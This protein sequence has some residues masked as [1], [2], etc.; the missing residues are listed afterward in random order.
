M[1]VPQVKTS[2]VEQMTQYKIEKLERKA[3]NE[4]LLARVSAKS[5]K[6]IY[7]F[8]YRLLGCFEQDEDPRPVVME[9]GGG[10]TASLVMTHLLNRFIDL[11]PA[12]YRHALCTLELTCGSTKLTCRIEAHVT[13]VLRANLASVKESGFSGADHYNYFKDRLVGTTPKGRNKALTSEEVDVMLEPALLFLVDASGVPVLLS[14][15]VLIFSAGGDDLS[16]L[17]TNQYKLY[18]LGIHHAI[19]KRLLSIYRPYVD[20]PVD[21]SRIMYNDQI[22]TATVVAIWQQMFALTGGQNSEKLLQEIARGADPEATVTEKGAAAGKGEKGGKGG[23]GGEKNL[24]MGNENKASGDVIRAAAGLGS[25]DMLYE[26]LRNGAH[27]LHIAT[28]GGTRTV[29]NKIELT[30]AKNIRTIVMTLVEANLKLIRDSDSINTIGLTMLR[31]VAVSN[32]L[33]GRRHF[34]AR[35]V[36]RCLLKELPLSEALTLWLHLDAMDDGPPLIKALET[37]TEEAEGQ[38][39]FKHL[40]FQEGLFAQHLFEE[41]SEGRWDGWTTDASAAAFLNDPFMNNTCRIASTRFGSLLGRQ[42]PTWN[43]SSELGDSQ[44]LQTQGK[45]AL[46][47]LANPEITALNLNETKCGEDFDEAGEGLGRML[48]IGLKIHTLCLADNFI[49]KLDWRKQ[50]FTRALSGSESLTF[51]NIR[52]NGLEDRG[53]RMICTALMTCKNLRSLDISHN[54]PFREPALP[55][56]LRH[57]RQP[58][59]RLLLRALRRQDHQGRSVLSFPWGREH[60]KILQCESQE[61]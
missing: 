12:H 9:V 51:L 25:D 46:W 10:L 54:R 61:S 16:D 57:H 50:Q 23:K 58:A 15:L 53:V 32:Q 6:A 14:L 47:L 60:S 1:C 48:S 36:A 29:L 26:L 19:N 39:Q 18:T 31:N 4:P 45:R 41:A 55:S 11:D 59:C 13:D 22:A 49:G 34:G 30:I 27:Y 40:S 17:P 21:G 42:R 20:P 7:L 33:Q 8:V 3:E 37:Q 5:G 44:K 24:G 28:H 35:D 38:Y 43:F 56:L 52:N 2:A